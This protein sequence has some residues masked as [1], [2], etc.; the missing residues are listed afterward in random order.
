MFSQA[1]VILFMGGGS[2]SV[3]DGIPPGPPQQQTPPGGGTHPTGMQSCFLLFSAVYLL[4]WG[5][6]GNW[7]LQ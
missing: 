5:S 2:A 3:H 4:F 1:C 6:F 7:Q